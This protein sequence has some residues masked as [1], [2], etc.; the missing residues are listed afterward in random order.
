MAIPRGGFLQEGGARVG[1]TLVRKVACF[2]AIS[3]GTGRAYPISYPCCTC[4]ALMRHEVGSR[5]GYSR[6]VADEL[7]RLWTEQQLAAELGVH[8]ETLARARR[9]GLIGHTRIGNGVRYTAAHVTAYLEAQERGPSPP[10]PQAAAGAPGA[11][12]AMSAQ[13]AHRLAL[14]ISGRA[15]S[16][17]VGA[18]PL[19]RRGL[20]D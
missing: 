4:S 2:S 10:S 17:S 19:G 13:N 15:P 12:A 6:R 16:T 1:I 7:P 18:A 5:V 11:S 3:E 20:T 9:A 8:K 14:E